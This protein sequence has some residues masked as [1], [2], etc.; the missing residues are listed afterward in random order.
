MRSNWSGAAPAGNP[1]QLVRAYVAFVKMAQ[2]AWKV[3]RFI[4][5]RKRR[6]VIGRMHVQADLAVGGLREISLKTFIDNE[7]KQFIIKNT[8]HLERHKGK[9]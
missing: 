1:G 8:R 7:A 3:S 2:K 9:S 5:S 4:L 6:F